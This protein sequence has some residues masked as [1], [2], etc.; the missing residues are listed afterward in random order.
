MLVLLTTVGT[1]V[2][3][4]ETANFEVYRLYRWISRGIAPIGFKMIGDRLT[5]KINESSICD[6]I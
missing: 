4:A 3:S 6:V 1:G 5:A 2:S